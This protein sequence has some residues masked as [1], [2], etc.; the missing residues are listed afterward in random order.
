VEGPE[1][2]G[3][4]GQSKRIEGFE[5]KL[6]GE[7]PSGLE[8]RYNVH[9]QNKGWLYDVN[10]TTSWPKDGEYAGT[11]GE[12]LRIEAIKI[13]LADADGQSVSGYSVL[14]RGH[15]QNIGDLPEDAS[16]W[17]KDG[18]QL[19][20][21]GSSLRLE[22]LMVKVEKNVIEPVVYDT[23]GTY[24][25]ETETQSI[26]GDVKICADG[27]I[28]Q[29]LL[30]QGDLTISEAVGD[31]DVTLNNV[32]VE[33]DTVVR[34]CGINSIHING[35]SYKK[36]TV[37][38]T[39]TGQV[40]IVALDLNG[41]EVVISEDAEGQVVLLEGQFDSVTANAPN[42]K[43]TTQGKD[44][45]IGNLT[46]G[47]DAAGCTVTLNSGT[48][49]DDL[50]LDGTAAVKGE[51][52]VHRA[53][54]N[55]DGVI[56]EKA[57]DSHTVDPEVVIPPVIPSTDG[58]GG[59][60]VPVAVTGVSL[61]KTVA[62]V[63]KDGAETL[64]ETVAPANAANK[65]VS[66]SSDNESI[67]TVDTDGKVTGVAEGMAI[68]TV[69]TADG[70]KTATCTVTVKDLNPAITGVTRP[71]YEAIA[72]AAIDET[73]QYSG[74]IQWRVKDGDSLA[75]GGAF[76]ASTTYV[77]TITLTLKAPYTTADISADFFTVTE[78]TVSNAAN[79]LE[80]IAEFPAT[81]DAP[82][83]SVTG[84]SLNKTNLTLNKAGEETLTATVAPA[85]ATN[86]AVNWSSNNESVA[87]VDT[88]GKVTGVAEG[89]AII[90]VMTA[91]GGK[92]AT[93][94]V[95][96]KDLKA[97]I[98][99]VNQPYYGATADS[100]IDE[101]A[102]YTGTI[103]WRVKDGSAVTAGT[104]F[105]AS[106]TY[107]ATITLTLKDPYTT[108]DITAN[109][110]TVAG[111]TSV[112][113]AAN[114]PVITAEFP[115]TGVF[116]I[117]GAG[118]IT[119]YAGAGGDVT[120]PETVGGIEVTGIGVNVFRSKT[121]LTKISIPAS[122]TSIGD[123][124]FRACSELTTVTF[125]ENAALTT[126][127]GGAFYECAKLG[128]ITIPANVLTVG[129]SAFRA[130]PALATVTFA[131][132]AVQTIGIQAFDGSKLLTAIA[133]PEAVTSI[134]EK[135]FYDCEQLATVT[136]AANSSLQTIGNQGFA[137]CSALPGMAVP[138]SVTTIGN[139]AFQ[140]CTSL[141]TVTFAANSV[142]ATISPATFIG[143]SALTGITIPETVTTIGKNAF[144]NC[145]NLAT[146]TFAGTS[147]LS[148]I[149]IETFDDCTSLTGITIPASVTA[150]KDNAFYNCTGLTTVSFAGTPTLTTIGRESFYNCIA[151]TGI[152][153]PQSVSS[154]GGWSFQNCTNLTTVSFA[155]TPTITTFGNGAFRD[156]SKLATI[157]IPETV[158]TIGLYAFEGCTAVGTITIPEKVT[159]IDDYAFQNC[160]GLTTVSFTGT[161]TLNLIGLNAFE[162]CT[163][164]SAM[165][166]PETVT[167]IKSHAFDGCTVLETVT[168]AGTSQ[169]TTIA[170]YTF[171][172]C[173]ALTSITIP[174]AVTSTGNYAFQNCIN[175]TNV[176]FAETATFAT[177]G[178]AT[179]KNCQALKTITLPESVTLINDNAFN[180]CT[181]LT[182]TFKGN[183]PAVGTTPIPAD[184]VIYYYDGKTGFDT[185]YWTSFNPIRIT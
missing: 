181:G 15:V 149:E 45:S 34:G 72:E 162:N 147:R 116:Q 47:S 33:G 174:A 59:V 84:V 49:V 133:I 126:I 63:N 26:E 129:N 73:A 11:R 77:A 124:A 138:A 144:Q 87:T 137:E 51:G 160:A 54:V 100:I 167:T 89:T 153:I 134:G 125:A 79:S 163:S 82:L 20:T 152:E 92:T 71:V 17:I 132:S 48:T 44:T 93:C 3:T 23:A 38:T 29:N 28:L 120:I 50:V 103:A 176:S 159:K 66:W 96:V 61:N 108:A 118:M 97:D 184:T 158:A 121:A 58:G 99:G 175:L 171:N 9:V 104:S 43:L 64:T 157:T 115:S 112:S 135:A 8:L 136:F 60:V 55:A 41:L 19:G 183:A 53:E 37:E 101:T 130:C 88:A 30:I 165:T 75:A 182:I 27:V 36:I 24:G 142:L 4:V 18:E 7:I 185:A 177:I 164:L 128:S 13:I 95:T 122:V 98:A 180:L 5:I 65:A 179:F 127:D 39:P 21:V 172:D 113:N 35:G 62:T 16:Q 141:T 80:V 131:G 106:T 52:K 78:A 151:L 74:T 140:N 123:S 81:G 91:D 85:N 86:P 154:F 94:N 31:G 145:T 170:E 76:A 143:C 90:T 25:Q 114:S 1:I 22:A 10:D 67:A 161:S 102:Q 173:Q 155:G 107:V 83:V 57:P 32:T 139:N 148:A 156:C 12:S 110:F 56:F 111:A 178:A 42:M 109:F 2:I 119:A 70:N 150:I 168:F 166:I 169:I 6:T 69:T 146:V 46:V 117:N 14:Y 40:R 105:A 68:I